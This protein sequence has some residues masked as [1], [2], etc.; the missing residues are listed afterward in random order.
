MNFDSPIDVTSLDEF[1]VRVRESSPFAELHANPFF[2]F[3]KP[4]EEILSIYRIYKPESKLMLFAD[5]L[6][7]LLLIV[8]NIFVS[9]G[10]SLYRI[11]ES[12]PIKLQIKGEKKFLFLSH[13]THAQNPFEDDI[14][15]GKNV[16]LEESFTLYLN[17]TRLN[18]SRILRMFHNADKTRV[19]VSPKTLPP[20]Q[21]F[22]IQINQL[23]VSCWLMRKTLKDKKLS[24]EQR[25]ILINGASLQHSRSTLANLILIRRLCEVVRKLNPN[26]LVFTIEGHAHERAILGMMSSTFKQKKLVAYQ[27]APVVPGQRN[28]FRIASLL[29]EG[30]T[31][32]TS[33]EILF[34]LAKK[35][36]LRCNVEILGSPKARVCE[37]QPKDSSR[38]QV[39]IAPEGTRK[40]LTQFLCL[41]N[42]LA[43]RLPEVNFT[44]RP[45]P[46]LGSLTDKIIKKKLLTKSTV[47]ISSVS[48][49][50]DL[51]KSHLI[52]FRSSAVGIEGLS[53]GAFPISVDFE[54][55]NSLNPLF[56]WQNEGMSLKSTTEIINYLEVFDPKKSNEVAFQNQ[57]FK[58]FSQ[59]FTELQDINSIV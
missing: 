38:L 19:V 53:F 45:H 24:M 15:F 55:S 54:G 29:N 43:S 34:E 10:I 52:L 31:L 11:R 30:D 56:Y 32:M 44:I 26:Y 12:K 36:R 39:L 20:S 16:D 40:S 35:N 50:E 46:A 3:V 58:I 28:F 23:R 41:T 7:T 49:R 57:C 47:T 18:S 27:H 6:K 59:Y 9:L 1:L 42:E 21:L 48:L 25:R 13:F 5:F 17:H 33:G 37:Y 51:L 8:A 22:R 14:F 4:T 2:Y